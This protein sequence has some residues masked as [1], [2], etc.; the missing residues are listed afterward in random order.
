MDVDA[1]HLY[2]TKLDIPCLMMYGEADTLISNELTL[3]V[4]Q[5]VSN[6]HLLKHKG[7][8]YVSTTKTTCDELL[9]WL[10]QIQQ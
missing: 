8:H 3:E 4:S 2:E 7:G 9:E 1:A 5:H 10:T 6:L